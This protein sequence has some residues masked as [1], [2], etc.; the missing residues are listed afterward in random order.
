LTLSDNQA[1]T[2]S[3]NQKSESKKMLADL[4]TQEDHNLATGRRFKL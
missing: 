1:M 4:K 2:F 3:D